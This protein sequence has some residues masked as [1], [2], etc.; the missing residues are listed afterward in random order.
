MHMEVRFWSGW[1]RQQCQEPLLPLLLGAAGW[2]VYRR[3]PAFAAVLAAAAC[4][5]LVNQ[6]AH[7]D[8][9]V[10]GARLIVMVWLLPAV[11]L[12]LLADRPGAHWVTRGTGAGRHGTDEECTH[13]QL[14]PPGAPARTSSS[15]VSSG[16]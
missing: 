6:A 3:S 7:P 8:H 5:G 15:A 14:P 12:P 2:A 9:T 16:P 10:W 11:G 4:S 13:P 1:V